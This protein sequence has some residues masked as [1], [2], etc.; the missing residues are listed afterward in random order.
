MVYKLNSLDKRAHEIDDDNFNHQMNDY[1]N[2]VRINKFNKY[3]KQYIDQMKYQI[4]NVAFCEK[5]LD[6]MVFVMNEEPYMSNSLHKLEF[7]LTKKYFYEC[8]TNKIDT[9]ESKKIA[10]II[11]TINN[12]EFKRTFASEYDLHYDLDKN[13]NNNIKNVC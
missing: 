3:I 12:F 7:Y 2:H 1:F 6:I 8:S 9:E 11:T 13:M 4:L 10:K 5:I